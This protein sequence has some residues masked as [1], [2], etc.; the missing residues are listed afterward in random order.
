MNLNLK[1]LHCICFLFKK[2]QI[3]YEKMENQNQQLQLRSLLWRKFEFLKNTYQ[4][5]KL[6][7]QNCSTLHVDKRKT[8]SCQSK[9]QA[10]YQ[11]FTKMKLKDNLSRLIIIHGPCHSGKTP[12]IFTNL[13]QLKINFEVFNDNPENSHQNFNNFLQ[14]QSHNFY[15]DKSTIVYFDRLPVCAFSSKRCRDLND[16]NISKFG[17]SK[18]GS[19]DQ[20]FGNLVTF[21]ERI[22]EMRKL[23]ILEINTFS[24]DNDSGGL[25]Y[26]FTKS[27]NQALM[28]LKA[29]EPYQKF[30]SEIK[31]N[32]PTLKMVN[33]Y[34][35]DRGFDKKNLENRLI[36]MVDC[37]FRMAE[38]LHLEKMKMIGINGNIN[39][40]FE[41]KLANKSNNLTF[42]HTLGKVMFNKYEP[43]ICAAEN[44][45]FK[46]IDQNENSVDNLINK[47]FEHKEKF[48]HDQ[49]KKS[50]VKFKD[51]AQ[52]SN[53]LSK[54]SYLK[55]SANTSD[56]YSSDFRSSYG[57]A[58]V[59]CY[60]SYGPKN[61]KFQDIN[62]YGAKS[63]AATLFATNENKDLL[64]PEM[65]SLDICVMNKRP[66]DRKIDM[67]HNLIEK[68]QKSNSNFKSYVPEKLQKT[69]SIFE[70]KH[71]ATV[72]FEDI[73]SDEINSDSGDELISESE[74]ETKR[75]FENMDISDSD[76]M[77][78][79]MA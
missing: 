33:S 75:D 73:G 39:N 49:K 24:D 25:P 70:E 8:S 68:I 14:N 1:L 28:N 48:W 27:I 60:Q 18:N 78:V 51:L 7:I 54:L 11:Y 76:L 66:N 43:E 56:K 12:M 34:M 59:S 22:F 36:Q 47:I 63:S 58:I 41:I 29:E 62:R 65:K 46:I 2:K 16:S 67:C 5:P 69:P 4:P 64:Y 23:I 19:F 74:D 32:R 42:F 15:D 37:N 9:I 45:P 40:N 53:N 13:A 61:V 44:S 3:S 71:N 72:R 26:Y 10:D 77:N 21:F 30:Y 50:P 57:T 52:F 31:I 38:V 17:F 55:N 79:T 6:P 35:I 20:Y